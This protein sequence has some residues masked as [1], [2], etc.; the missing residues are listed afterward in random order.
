MT[1][2]PTT[3]EN[4]GDARAARLDK[5]HKIEA[6]GLDPWGGRFDNR[7]MIGDI[8]AKMGEIVFVAED[9]KDITETGRLTMPTAAS[10]NP[11]AAAHSQLDSD[12]GILTGNGPRANSGR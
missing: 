6:L 1:P 2:D 10:A 4:T 11:D 3:S 7:L 9:G 5:L 8:R 12:G